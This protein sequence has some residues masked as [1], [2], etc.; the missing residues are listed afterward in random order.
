MPEFR[1]KF[2]LRE[3]LDTSRAVKSRVFGEEM[4]MV[5]FGDLINHRNPPD[6]EWTM[7]AD[8]RGRQGWFAR[9]IQNVEKGEQVF[10]S[11]G[12]QKSN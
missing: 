7:E 5:P 10:V 12:A 4:R 9:A 3:F 8:E 11:Y 2:T 1:S 6:L